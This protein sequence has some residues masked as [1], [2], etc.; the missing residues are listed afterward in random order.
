MAGVKKKTVIT[1]SSIVTRN[2]GKGVE[3]TKTP[4]VRPVPT[5][6]TPPTTES[7]IK[8]LENELRKAVSKFTKLESEMNLIKNQVIDQSREMNSVLLNN[9]TA[10]SGPTDTHTQLSE[11]I[12]ALTLRMDSMDTKNEKK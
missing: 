7:R 11:K 9:S 12:D 6:T 4:P 5:R 10:P 8:N 1:L 2:K 3:S